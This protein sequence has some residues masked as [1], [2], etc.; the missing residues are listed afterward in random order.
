MEAETKKAV[1][2]SN[3]IKTK[4]ANLRKETDTFRPRLAML[5][6]LEPKV[7]RL[8]AEVSHNKQNNKTTFSME[9]EFEFEFDF[10]RASS[11]QI[12]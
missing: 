5:D 4:F 10:Y 11:A 9:F 3:D 6:V 8:Q 1:A 7:D 2:E 12:S